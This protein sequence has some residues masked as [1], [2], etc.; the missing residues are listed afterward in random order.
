M[1]EEV[2]LTSGA[3]L[4][5]TDNLT[6]PDYVR[7]NDPESSGF[8]AAHTVSTASMTA[9]Q[10][11]NGHGRKR[12]GFLASIKAVVFS[13]CLF[14]PIVSVVIGIY[15]G[16]LRSEPFFGFPSIRL[17]FPPQTLER[18]QD[19]CVYVP[20]SGFKYPIRSLIRADLPFLS[21]LPLHHPFGEAFRVVWRANGSLPRIVPGRLAHNHSQQYRRSY[22]GYRPS[23]QVRVSEIIPT[24][25]VP[26]HGRLQAEGTSIY[27]NRS[28]CA[29]FVAHPWYCFPR[30][31]VRHL[32]TG[33]TPALSA[34]QQL[35]FDGWVSAPNLATASG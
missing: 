14:I 7:H 34:T 4:R 22:S 30:W 17:G 5:S 27:Y 12:V 2:P 35:S 21:M 11:F 8:M 23:G 10:R 1:D 13:S 20:P 32:G 15:P 25:H 33:S 3:A 28:Y 19:L 26:P 6:L 18:R 31:R 9:W 16:F 29:A 24:C